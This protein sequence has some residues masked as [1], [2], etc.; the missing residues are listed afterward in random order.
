MPSFDTPE[1]RR[2]AHFQKL[3]EEAKKLQEEKNRVLEEKVELELL[4]WKGRH[5]T[6]E[7][8]A[9]ENKIQRHLQKQIQEENILRKI[10]QEEM[11][12]Q[13]QSDEA[14]E[15]KWAEKRK[16]IEE[17]KRQHDVGAYKEEFNMEGWAL[18][19]LDMKENAQ[20]DQETII[21]K[22]EELALKYNPATNPGDIE[23]EEIFQWVNTVYTS[24]S[25]ICKDREFSITKTSNCNF[26]GPPLDFQKNKYFVNMLL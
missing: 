10:K 21:E 18:A 26:S 16:K 25:N 3:K 15:R 11:E 5:Q 19:T 4:L 8:I 12:L 6:E 22:Y 1:D 20:Y 9:L 13:K 7:D 17:K 23:S 2:K 14:Q 24:L